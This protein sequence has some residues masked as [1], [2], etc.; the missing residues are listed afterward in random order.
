MKEFAQAGAFFE[1]LAPE[2][3]EQ[4]CETLASDLYFLS[5]AMQREI[6]AMLEQIHPQLGAC[7]RERNSFTM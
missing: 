3:K 7:V 1:E 6:L 4:L 2:E 5:D